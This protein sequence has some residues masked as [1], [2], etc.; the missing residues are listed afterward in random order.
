MINGQKIGCGIVTFNRPEGLAKL[1][2]S[3]PHDLLDCLV[4]VND[5][6]WYNEFDSYQQ[7][8]ILD[9]GVNLGVGK[10]KN[11]ALAFMLEAG[12]EHIFL[13]EDDIFVRDPSVFERYILASQLTGIQHFNY[14]QHGLMN[15]T[16]EGN[17]LSRCVIDYG[18]GIKVPLFP[19]CVGA[20]SYYSRACL[21]SV[22]LID[23]TFHNAF[24]HVDHTL[25]VIMHGMHPPFWFFADIEDSQLYLGDELWSVEQSTISSAQSHRDNVI[26]GLAYFKEKNGHLPNNMPLAGGDEVIASVQHI[27]RTYGMT[28]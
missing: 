2:A 15:R 17:P 25:C 19:H 14:S 7:C 3:L 8:T 20:F 6:N 21:D 27:Q 23:E 22:G 4:I 5:G 18:N 1:Y 28:F 24:E 13:I 16:P 10:S 9:N 12:C 26:Q 11:K